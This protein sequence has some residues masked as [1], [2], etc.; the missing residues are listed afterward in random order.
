MKDSSYLKE[1]NSSLPIGEEAHSLM[2]E[3]DLW[4]N[5]TKEIFSAAVAAAEQRMTRR[6]SDCDC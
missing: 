6:P 3:R 1:E 2:T 4:G 5:E